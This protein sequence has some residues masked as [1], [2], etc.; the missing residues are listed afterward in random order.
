MYVL[1]LLLLLFNII[2]MFYFIGL[3]VVKFMFALLPVS[4]V[5]ASSVFFKGSNLGSH[6]LMRENRRH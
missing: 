6:L 5:Q 2:I 1:L 3:V 4:L